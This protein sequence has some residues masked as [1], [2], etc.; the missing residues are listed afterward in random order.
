MSL[1]T[2]KNNYLRQVTAALKSCGLYRKSVMQAIRADLEDYLDEHPDAT[3]QALQA[4][5]GHP[6]DYV[7][8]FLS[9]M[10]SEELSRNLSAKAFRRNLTIVIVA[11]LLALAVALGLW[12]GIGNSRTPEPSLPETTDATDPTPEQTTAPTVNP[13]MDI[14]SP[15]LS[16]SDGRYLTADDLE[17]LSVMEL[18]L[19]R[20]EI[21]AR[22]GVI[23][24]DAELSAY[25][26]AQPWYQAA[27]T[28]G[29]FDQA[30]LSDYEN[31]NIQLI[32]IYEK[33]ADGDYAPAPGNPYM[34]YYDP[35]VELLLPKRS[36]TKLTEEDLAG[37]NADQLLLL[38]NQ[39]IA[40]HGYAFEDQALMEYFLQCA[41]YR[42]S[43]PTG[44]TD[45]IKGMS[46]LEYEN[47]S[48]IF[49]YE[50]DH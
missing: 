6:Q 19:A 46:A 22:H 4:Q 37:M 11:A 35:D 29:D 30:A 32:R 16:D 9:G 47:M 40:L 42:P 12:I 36:N 31:V 26:D 18:V 45:L 14:S 17:Q 39:I 27:V 50:Q 20:S 43:V 8:E 38:R 44:R 24:H 49:Q 10:S 33:I 25:F 23:F 48:F 2:Q 34:P 3:E 15:V 1:R 28:E 21:L 13:Y 7:K 41:W 5:F